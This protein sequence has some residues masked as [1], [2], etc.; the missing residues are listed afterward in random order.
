LKALLAEQ[1]PVAGHRPWPRYDL[2]HTAWITVAR[3]LGESG[4][5]LLSF[6]GDKDNAYMALRVAGEG[7]PCVVSTAVKGTD[8]PSVGRYH[9]PAIRLERAARDLYGYTPIGMQDRRPWLDH[10]AWALRAPLGERQI[11]ARRDPAGYEFSP[12]VGEGL[13]QIPV[14][15]VHA[16][17]IEP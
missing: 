15:P 4:G 9:T 7:L 13:H 12:V 2:D 17:I 1:A 11:S 16:G 6:W 5:D 14:G 3:E 10:G 8:I